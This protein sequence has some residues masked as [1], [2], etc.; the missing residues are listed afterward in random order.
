MDDIVARYL[1]YLR[2]NPEGYWFKRKV[3]GWGWVPSTWQ[4]WLV[5][6]FFLAVFVWLL[7]SFTHE[8][9]PDAVAWQF[10]AKVFVWAAALIGVCYLTGEPPKWQWG[11]PDDTDRS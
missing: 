9:D 10:L 6:V 7:V 8:P 11:I 5:L 4:G 2:H 1:R 3:Y